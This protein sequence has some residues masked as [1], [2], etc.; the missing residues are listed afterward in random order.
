MKKV[1]ITIPSNQWGTLNTKYPVDSKY[2]S[3]DELTQGS[4][5][6]DT[7]E[8]GV[9]TKRLDYVPYNP[10]FLA[11]PIK[12][13]YEA[14]FSNGTHHLLEVE[15]GRLSYSSGD[16]IFNTV[17]SGYSN[18]G[19]FEFDL[20]LDRV[21]F[22][23]GINDPQVYDTTAVYGGVTYSPV[24]KTKVMGCEPPSSAV[25]FNANTAGGNVPVGGHTY[26]VTF[27][28]YN[29]LEESN[30]SPISIVNTVT[31][32]NQTVNLINIP[33]GGYGVVARN[34]YRDDNDSVWRYVGTVD[35]NT[36]TIFSDTASIGTTLIPTDQGLPPNFSLITVHLDRIWTA[37]IPGDF[38]TLYYSEAGL[39]DIFGHANFIICNPTD[40][41]MGIIVYEN[42]I[43][44]L[45][46]NSMGQI[47][48]ST[49]ETFRY[50]PIPSTVGCV[51]NRTMR[52]RVIEG[53]PTLLWLS[54]KG[55]YQYNGNSIDYISDTIENL[56]NVNIQQAVVTKGR[57]T[58][59]TQADFQAASIPPGEISPGIDL[60]SVPDLIVTTGPK[61]IAGVHIGNPINPRRDWQTRANWKEIDAS[62]TNIV[63]EIDQT[64]KSPTR[65]APTLASGSLNNLI[66]DNTNSLT[67]TA[68]TPYTG[69]LHNEFG[70]SYPNNTTGADNITAYA[71]SVIVP[72]EGV[73]TG[74]SIP[75]HATTGHQ[76]R[77]CVWNDYA[78]APNTKIFSGPTIT[79]TTN[80]VYGYNYYQAV[81]GV[82][83]PA[84]TRLWVGV[85]PLSGT[86]GARP[87]PFFSETQYTPTGDVRFFNSGVWTTSSTPY[88]SKNY[89]SM[90]YAI[91]F[92]YTYRS[93][94]GTWASQI[95]DTY[96][97]YIS[98]T[99][100]LQLSGV[101]YAFTSGAVTVFGSND[102]VLFDV[103]ESR[104]ITIIS[105]MTGP[106]S[107]SNRRYW[108]IS[109]QL[110]TDNDVSVPKIYSIMLKF[111][112]TS[113]W[114]SAPF[115]VS[116][117]IYSLDSLT[118]VTDI[119]SG[120]SIVTTIATSADNITYTPFTDISS[121]TPQRY[122]KIKSIL[123]KSADDSLTPSLYQ[124][125]LKWTLH[126]YL[127]SAAIDTGLTNNGWDIFQEVSDDNGGSLAFQ[128]RSAT[129][130][131]GL[132]AAPWFTVINGEFPLTTVNKWVQWKVSIVAKADFVPQ[133]ESVQITWFISTSGVSVR[134]ASFFF[135]KSYY[136]SVAEFN[137]TTNNVILIYDDTN[138]WRI[139]RELNFSTMGLF[140][141]DFYCGLSTSG[142]IVKFLETNIGKV[143][144]MDIRTKAL[145]F[146]TGQ[147]YTF[148]TLQ[149]TKLLKKVYIV[150]VNTGA[151]YTVSVSYDE[152]TTFIPLVDP[153]TGATTI[154]TTLDN[155]RFIKRLVQNCDLGQ[156]TAGKTIL[157]RI[158]E[159]TSAT[160]QIHEIKAEA[161]IREGELRN[162]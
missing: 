62:L 41:I 10:T 141:N 7:S 54:D 128:M 6:F 130:S 106:I 132:S 3:Q 160:A 25:D 108:K 5:N 52:I 118:T 19:Y 135:G 1:Q 97:N 147:D 70:A 59:T 9:I 103:Q 100:N 63:T 14:I 29:I 65:F 102:G 23:N 152:G 134:A 115:D 161:W 66:I 40:P 123:T 107:L 162:V 122:I 89:K 4:K 60:L 119:P 46:R 76:F 101:F 21:Y 69:E 72:R 137:Q 96:S 88:S 157:L 127:I 149:K 18:N 38:S 39:P 140:F 155:S 99:L 15:G 87:S 11:S 83:V 81:T 151:V 126:S 142:Q 42:R 17:T 109:L 16:G 131:G 48:G 77:L 153:E 35:N 36:A 80:A 47:L 105:G 110:N 125:T 146:S 20:Y 67:M 50:A 49:P 113:T 44:V 12:D 139:Y 64:M 79:S 33:I 57:K 136:L 93:K 133:V 120:T 34:I 98:P 27:V 124:I 8:K 117:D 26:K 94:S 82:S 2:I 104:N 31:A 150:G 55:V 143:I 145:D 30:E 71:Q 56:L 37:G 129:T 121:A 111:A 114:I 90:L 24:P 13:Q 53:I 91:F 92:S 159:N 116:A 84:N 22:G 148:D 73:L 144:E 154:T 74:I 51:D 85:E 95:Y 78:N 112:P 138:K 28:Y 43:I 75:V 45:N 156:P 58:D 32:P 158:H 61:T 68:S 86:G